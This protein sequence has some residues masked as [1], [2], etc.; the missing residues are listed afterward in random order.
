MK[1]RIR[2]SKTEY[3]NGLSDAEKERLKEIQSK[4]QKTEQK[5]ENLL[6]EANEREGVTPLPTEDP[7]FPMFM[8]WFSIPEYAGL[9]DWQ[10]EHHDLTWEAKYDMTLAPRDHGKS[11]TLNGKYQ[12]AMQFKEYDVLLLGWTDRRKEIAQYVYNFFSFYNLIES[13]KRTSPFHFKILNGGRFDCYLITSKETLGMHSEGDQNRFSRISEAEFDEYQ[14][15]FG[16]TKADEEDGVSADDRPFT[17]DELKE[18]VAS[19]TT[20]HRKLWISIDDPIDISFM[21][22]RHKEDM[23]ELHFNSSLYGIHPD[24]W[25]FTGTRKFEGDFFDFISEKFG[26]ELVKYVRST[27]NPDGTLLCPEKFTHPTVSRFQEELNE[28]KRDLS[29]VREHIG[30]Y[31]WHSEYEQNPHPVTGEVWDHLCF[32]ENLE[33]PLNRKHDICFISVDRAT[34]LRRTSDYTGCIIGLRET[35]SG[36][37]IITHDYSGHEAFDQLLHRINNFIVDFHNKHPHPVIILVVEKQGG[38]DDFITMATNMREFLLPDG[39]RVKN[40]IPELAIIE[41][42]HNTGEKLERI[43]QRLRAPIVNERVQFMSTLRHSEIAREILNFPHSAK[44]DAIDALANSEFIL[45]EVYQE[46]FNYDPI[47]KLTDMYTLATEGHLEHDEALTQEWQEEKALRN[48]LHTERE[49]RRRR[50]F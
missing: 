30:E 39:T 49:G 46:Q 44:L 50:V 45:L 28:G 26:A 34:T 41:P 4:D 14:S 12:W 24:K 6:P 35:Q 1:A 8:R 29:Q 18:Y 9:Y 33:T 23:L 37:R 47:R 16:I 32:V 20:T 2:V 42:I 22:E 19:R 13:D 3:K 5:L 21:K 38:G 17:L 7:G 36:R 11:V 15:L 48:T 27:M 25:S 40:S 10:Q 31:A 43:R